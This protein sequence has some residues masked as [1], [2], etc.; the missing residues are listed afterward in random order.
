[1][2]DASEAACFYTSTS[3]TGIRKYRPQSLHVGL[4]ITNP[5]AW[6]LLGAR[7]G[8]S[9]AQQVALLTALQRGRAARRSPAPFRIHM[10]ETWA[11]A[12]THPSC[13]STAWCTFRLS[14][15][16]WPM[17]CLCTCKVQTGSLRGCEVTRQQEL[18]GLALVLHQYIAH[19]I[20]QAV[21]RPI[22]ADNHSP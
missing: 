10:P 3:G 1:M 8:P 21:S 15:P 18:V 20:N 14:M 4:G 11:T 22:A 16:H 5:Q 6:E 17:K 13:L 19:R 9:T 12:N 2:I 7:V